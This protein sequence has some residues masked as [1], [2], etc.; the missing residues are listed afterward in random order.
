MKKIKIFLASSNEL[1]ADREAFEREIY[2]KSK[3]W[4]DKGVSL[5]L[6]IWED[7]SAAVSQSRSQDE[8]N[9]KIKEADIFVLLAYSKVGIYTAEEF[10]Q[11][12]ELFKKNKKIRIFTYFK[13][14]GKEKEGNLEEFKKELET[15]AVRI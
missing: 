8:Y 7:L 3:T 9:K 10:G 12:Y 15:I 2:R 11:A 14:S 4:I 13:N 6:E 1:L 5:H